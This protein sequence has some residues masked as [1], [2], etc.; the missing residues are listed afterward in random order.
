LKGSVRQ[1]APSPRKRFMTS[2]KNR[3]FSLLEMMIVVAIGLTMASI[4]FMAMMPMF[5]ENHVDQAYDT[6]LS[7]IRNYRNLSITQSRRYILTFTNVSPTVNQITVQYW[8]VAVP[9]S[10]APVTVATYNLP[11][12][13]Q[14]AVQ[15]GFPAASPDGFGTGIAPIDFDQGMGLGSQNYIMFMP[16]GSSQDTLGNYNS[17]IVYITRPASDKYSSRA[18]TVMGTTGRVRGWRLYNQAGVNNWVQQ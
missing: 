2:R 9:V 7:V 18:I 10:P 11:T 13:M 14:F 16:D 8:G 5:K 4:T 17:G 6:T 15:A 12:D 1:V 3:G